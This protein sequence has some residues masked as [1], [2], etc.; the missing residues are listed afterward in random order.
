MS[1]PQN[2]YITCYRFAAP[3][4]KPEENNN[5]ASTGKK[6]KRSESPPRSKKSKRGHKSDK[7]YGVS[8]G[9]DFVSVSC[10]LN[11]DLPS[12]SRAYVHRIGRTARA[13]KSGIAISFVVPEDEWGKDKVVGCVGT[14]KK[15]EKVF[16]R[17]V[18][19]QKQKG[20]EI[21]EWAFDQKQV[22]AFRYRMEDA[23]RSVT[24]RVIG[25]ARVKEITSEMLNSDKL[26][27]YFEDNPRTLEF[28]RHD[29]PLHPTR[30]QPHL[31]YVPK[32]LKQGTVPGEITEG[33]DESQE[34]EF[35]PFK[36]P[37]NHSRRG[38]GRG[39][40][41]KSNLG[42]KKKDPLKGVR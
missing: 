26:K 38:R 32:Y 11:F 5:S 42:R 39:R 36:K 15:D 7:E 31:K 37:T 14:T 6:R 21:K 27:A 35:I 19:K 1:S 3:E 20:H 25:E 10:V 9:I 41:G 24:K 30:I 8:R 23:L 2:Y 22:E 12:S 17:I 4:A 34:T 13:G 29:K 40:G 28:L 16:A 33:V 18:K